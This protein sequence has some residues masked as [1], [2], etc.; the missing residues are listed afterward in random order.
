MEVAA[1]APV[2]QRVLRKGRGL[3]IALGLLAPLACFGM[4]A[5]I[6]LFEWWGALVYTHALLTLG[7]TAALLAG[8]WGQRALTPQREALFA[9]A[10]AQGALAALCFA[11]MLLPF[12][13]AGLGEALA[14]GEPAF[15]FTGVLALLPLPVGW[16]YARHARAAL[17]SARAR[18]PRVLAWFALGC[19]LPA[20][21]GAGAQAAARALDVHCAQAIVEHG[22]AGAEAQELW[23]PSAGVLP[24]RALLEEYERETQ[25][26]T[27]T[28][29]RSSEWERAYALF[30]GRDHLA[31]E[32]RRHALD[33]GSLNAW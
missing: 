30:K 31:F 25:H 4:A 17:N 3:A 23:R 27:L 11:A 2:P 24:L 18:A 5:Y 9:G 19:A 33:F 20:A 1:T 16:L 14:L 28:T 15:A 26:F 6:G 12:G 21:C 29:E 8:T 13:I 22:L 10:L 32:A 7:A